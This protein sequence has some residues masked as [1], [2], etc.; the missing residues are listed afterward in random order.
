VRS[1]RL[2]QMKAAAIAILTFLLPMFGGVQQPQFESMPTPA[3]VRALLQSDDPKSKSWGAWWTAQAQMR[4]MEPLLQKNLEQ[5]YQGKTLLDEAVV[6]QTLDAY[7][8]ISGSP[9]VDLLKAVFSR[10][11]SQSLILLSRIPA[12][13][14]VDSALLEL[15]LT[16]EGR[17]TGVEWYAMADLLL[18]HR[19]QGFAASLLRNIK[20]TGRITV[21]DPSDCEKMMLSVSGPP[22]GVGGE[23]MLPVVSVPGAPPW[24]IY[25]LRRVFDHQAI[26]S[27]ST[28]I[29]ASGPVTIA[30]NRRVGAAGSS[31]SEQQSSYG[32]QVVPR[33]PTVADRLKYL[34]AL[35]SLANVP[36]EFEVRSV[37]WMG[38][39]NFIAEI[40]RLRENIRQKHTTLLQLLRANGVLSAQE[41]A[42]FPEPLIEISV[43]DV[44]EVK[45][46]L[47]DVQ[48]R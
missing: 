18:A 48:S 5:H 29:V 12:S 40:A 35:L 42:D 26:P 32:W 37:P 44:R 47:P 39:D 7:I 10:R 36:D 28:T 16:Q 6:D 23:G 14:S 43:S 30:Y 31:P 3:Q 24:P 45:T 2:L 22:M 41:A 33:I 8:Q 34:S 19:A 21:C 1:A 25:T 46:P 15:L 38:T 13:P 9:T 11:P 17:G 20:L 4:Q 27:F